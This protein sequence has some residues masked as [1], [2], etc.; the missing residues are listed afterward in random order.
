MDRLVRWEDQ[1]NLKTVQF[2]QWEDDSCFIAKKSDPI[3]PQSEIGNLNLNLKILQSAPI[4]DIPPININR[5]GPDEGT[6]E[7][8][9]D[10]SAESEGHFGDRVR[11]ANP[12]YGNVYAAKLVALRDGPPPAGTLGWSQKSL[13]DK[14]AELGY[15]RPSRSSVHRLLKKANISANIYSTMI[16]K[17]S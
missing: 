17:P 2:K 7:M 10:Q 16:T 11:R 6:L 13:A 15:K 9:N 12:T 5:S 14:I 3:I 8:E 4:V 1:K